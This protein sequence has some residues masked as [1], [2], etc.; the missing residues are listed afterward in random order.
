MTPETSSVERVAEVLQIPD[1]I[2][3]VT[4]GGLIILGAAGL[5]WLLVGGAAITYIPAEIVK[6]RTKKKRLSKG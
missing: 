5:G 4:G 1:K 2:M 6:R 3:F